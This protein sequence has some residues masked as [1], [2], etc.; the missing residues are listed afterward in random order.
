MFTEV[1]V[2]RTPMPVTAKASLLF[3]TNLE[4]AAS[5]SCFSFSKDADKELILELQSALLAATVDNIAES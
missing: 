4:S 1:G 2:D 5:L 3:S